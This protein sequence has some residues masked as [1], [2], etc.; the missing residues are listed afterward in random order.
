L[1]AAAEPANVTSASVPRLLQLADTGWVRAVAATEVL[2]WHSDLITKHFS[3][4]TVAASLY[5]P[6]GAIGVEIFFVLSG[7][8]MCMR[9]PT[10]ASGP[11]YLL[12]RVTRLT[13]LYWLFTTLVIAAYFLNRNWHLGGFALSAQHL[14]G[15][16]LMLPVAGF[17]I[18]MVGWTLAYEMIFYALVALLAAGGGYRGAGGPLVLFCTVFACGIAG[19]MQPQ[20]NPTDVGPVGHI[21]SPYM[22][23]FAFGWLVRYVEQNGGLRR[24]WRLLACV[25]GIFVLTSLQATPE[26]QRL[27]MRIALAVTCVLLFRLARPWLQRDNRVNRAACLLGASSYSLYLS[28]WFVLS[29]LGK[30]IAPYAPTGDATALRASGIALCLLVGL[31]VYLLIEQPVDRFLRSRLLPA[32]PSRRGSPPAMAT[33]S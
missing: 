15:S 22:L 9:A 26:A 13:P 32:A 17:P 6:F 8:I 1:S 27:A 18:L 5:R 20:V 30:A 16:Y 21:L 19:L 12:A 4:S 7:Y 23:N 28:H 14:A 3:A 33:I 31:A 25:A 2:I 10:Y 29:V 24:H 11:R